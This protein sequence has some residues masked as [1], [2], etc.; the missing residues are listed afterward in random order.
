MEW[1]DDWPRQDS[2]IS[3]YGTKYPL[4]TTLISALERHAELPNRPEL[5]WSGLK[6]M[7]RKRPLREIKGNSMLPGN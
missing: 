7:K 2:I 4:H 5:G 1:G 3:I 6:E